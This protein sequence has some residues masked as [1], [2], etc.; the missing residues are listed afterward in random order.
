[1]PNKPK[2]DK[3]SVKNN[4]NNNRDQNQK[5]TNDTTDEVEKRNNNNSYVNETMKVCP[6]SLMNTNQTNQKPKFSGVSPTLKTSRRQ[7]SSRFN[8]S[9][10]REIQK[11]PALKDATPSE[12]E[13]L[14]I[15]KLNQCCVL[16]DFATDPLSDLKWKEVKRAA[17]HELVEYIMT[18][19]NVI[20]E[21]IYPEVVNMVLN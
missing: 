9:Q 21:N 6:N 1:M 4:S 8:I 16:F 7:S 19:R 18:Q 5:E 13:E 2:K 14:F 3:I 12:R 17:L 10:N 11:L 15:Q 20:T